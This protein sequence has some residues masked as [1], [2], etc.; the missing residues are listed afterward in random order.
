MNEA[1]SLPEYNKMLEQAEQN[2][3]NLELMIVPFHITNPRTIEEIRKPITTLRGIK[4]PSDQE[5]PPRTKEP[6]I[7]GVSYLP[8]QAN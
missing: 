6:C 8:Y 3:K 5:L 4:K 1:L 7:V 2:R